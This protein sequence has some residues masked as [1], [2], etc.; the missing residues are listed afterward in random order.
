MSVTVDA[1]PVAAESIAEAKAYLRIADAGED[2]MI[3]RL[4]GVATVLCEGFTATLLIGRAVTETLPRSGDW[5]RLTLTPVRSIDAIQG[6]DGAGG[7]VTLPIDS[8]G[9][10]IDGNGDGWVRIRQAGGARRVTVHYSAGTA[11][12]WTGLPEPIRQ[13]IIRLTAHLYTHRDAA[14]DGGPPAAVAAL[15]RPWRRMRLR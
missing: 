12:G 10:D 3:E 7:T 11:D 14:D 9:I 5:K 15:W 8:Y 13:G 2:G 1:V 6:M 4:I